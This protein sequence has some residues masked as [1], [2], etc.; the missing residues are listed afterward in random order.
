MDTYTEFEMC[1]QY[2]AVDECFSKTAFPG[3]DGEPMPIRFSWEGAIF[4]PLGDVN[5]RELNRRS[6]FK[7]GLQCT[8]SSAGT[9][10]TIGE[11]IIF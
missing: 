6:L 7:L 3:L 2:G 9:L 10:V 8:F 4:F 5:T 11:E 1:L